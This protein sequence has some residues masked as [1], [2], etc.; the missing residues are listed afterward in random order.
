MAHIVLPD[1]LPGITG[2]LDAYPQTA[3]PLLLLAQI[4]L[5][6]SNGLEQWEREF[7][8]AYVSWLNKCNFCYSSHRAAAEAAK[9]VEFGSF[10]S[11]FREEGEEPG[12]RRDYIS[13]LLNALLAIAQKVQEKSGKIDEKTIE[14]AK[15]AGATDLI[16]HDVVL[17]AAAF[18]MY[19]RYVDGLDT[20]SLPSEHPSYWEMGKRLAT[21][22]YMR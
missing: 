13:P 5:V 2:L 18:C 16:I 15:A 22:G 6:S 1:T 11:F 19:N 17:I 21:Y 7:I 9:G 14:E 10:C 8:A 4:L 12:S 3:E 20:E